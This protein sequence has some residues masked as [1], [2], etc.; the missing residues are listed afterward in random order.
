MRFLA[1]MGVSWRVVQYLIQ[2]GHEAIHIREEGLH[3]LPNGKIFDKA[4]AEKRIVLTFDLD[5]GEI[6]SRRAEVTIT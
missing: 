3:R 2:E 4:Y 1:D 6:I 5:F